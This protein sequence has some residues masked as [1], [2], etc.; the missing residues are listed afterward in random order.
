MYRIVLD[1]KIR[2]S[3]D[4]RGWALLEPLFALREAVPVSLREVGP[5]AG[6]IST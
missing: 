3:L 4:A 5:V 1:M 2:P 6:E